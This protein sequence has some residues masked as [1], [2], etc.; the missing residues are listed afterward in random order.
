M[1]YQTTGTSTS[2]GGM[3]LFET[4]SASTSTHLSRRELMTPDEIMRLN[5]SLEILLR[6][7]AAPAIA[8][9]VRYYDGPEFRDLFNPASV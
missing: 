8:A 1:S 2:R 3:Q 5:A 7:G 4:K 6:Q 9:K